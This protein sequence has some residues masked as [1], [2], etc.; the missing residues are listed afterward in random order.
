MP[1]R[2]TDELFQLVKSLEKAE[3]RNFKLFVQRNATSADM[4]TVQLF[5]AL[6]KLEDYD[7]DT[8]LKRNTDIKKQQLSNLKAHLYKQILASLR[9]LKDDNNIQLQLH[10]LMDYSRILYDKGLYLQ[11]LKTLEKVKEYAR[12]QHQVTYLLQTL[13][14]EKKIEA[15]YITRSMEN[16][17][18]ILA[19]EVEDAD[20]RL[21]MMNKLSNLSLQLYSW[22]INL[23]HARGDKDRMAIKAFFESNLP[24]TA[25][26]YN[27]FYERHYLYES[28]CWYGFILQDLLM[29]YRYC[30]KWVDAFEQESLMKKVDTPLY[31]KGVHN[32]LNAHFVLQNYDKFNITLNA[33][34]QF[35]H[36]KQADSNDN[37]RV[38]SFIYLYT[39][40]LNKHFLEGSF[41]A[42]LKL[43]PEIESRIAKFRL[44]MDRHRI[45]V[46]Y[47]K[48]ACLYFGSGDNEKAIE[49][50]N[51]IINWKVDLR[52]DLQCYS[53]LLHLIA[54][55]E[56]GNYTLLEYLVK[57]VYRFMAKMQNLSIVEEEIFRFLRKSFHIDQRQMKTAFV[58]L[59]G[60]LEKYKDNPLESRS[61]M[62]LD[63]ISWL[64]S[65]IQYVPVQEVIQQKYKQATA[66]KK[67]NRNTR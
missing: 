21:T 66:S 30:Q 56:L 1:K 43:V 41:T 31:I 28:Y 15:L 67:G 14:F 20:N 49:Y 50:L 13:I 54:H 53:R 25:A 11:S 17:A 4:K 7:E 59:K 29:Y 10:E 46:F 58:A 24:T 64:E 32:L 57:S 36:S 33:F 22:Y 12:E 18:E 34:E 3:K 23:G 35:C 8:L 9:I 55:Y 2:S 39:A 37:I 51:R 27:G 6:D 42:G 63:I 62:Y 40:K 47:Y 48:I 52:T 38:Q 45:L 16:R 60:K 5:D 61:F 19:K 26:H 44:K 65:K